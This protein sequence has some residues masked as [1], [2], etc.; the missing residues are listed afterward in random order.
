MPSTKSSS[1]PDK[2][3]AIRFAGPL[4][5]IHEAPAIGNGDLGALVQVFHNE[6]RLHL[7][8]S[9]AWDARAD[10]LAADHVLEQDELIRFERNFGFRWVGD[11][12][13]V[14]KPQWDK[15]PRGRARTSFESPGWRKTHPCPKPLGAIRVLHSGASSTRIDTVLDIAA[16]IVHTRYHLDY[17]EWGEGELEIAAFIHRERNVVYLSVGVLG[18]VGAFQLCIEKT[19][20]RMDPELPAPKAIVIDPSHGLVTQEI[21][22]AFDVDPFA[23]RLAGAFPRDVPGRQIKPLEARSFELLQSCRLDD[24]NA[25]EFAVGVATD[26][27]GEGDSRERALA[28]AGDDPAE[29]YP[30]A[31]KSHRKSWAAFWSAS[32]IALEDLELERS[33]Y[34]NLFA[35][36]CHL[37][38]DAVAPGLCANVPTYDKSAWHGGYTVNMNVQKMFLAALPT[39]HAEW[40]DGYANWLEAMGP[41][42]EYLAKLIFDLEGI[43]SEHMHLPFVPPHR[44]FISNTCGRALGMTGWHGQPLW[45]HWQ[46]RRDKTFLRRRAYP[47]L[48]KA[49]QFY[50]RY[51]DKYLD[52]SG[53]IFPSM[54]LETPGWTRG[55]KHNRNCIVDLI[56]F[57]HAFEW[58]IEASEILGVDVRW[59]ARWRDALAKV[60]AI[61]HKRLLDGGAWLAR[62]KG[63]PEPGKGKHPC[64]SHGQPMWAAW[65]VFPGEM[66][67]GDEEDGLAQIARDILTGMT[68][69]QKH[70][71]FTWIHLWW[72]AIPGLRLGL[73]DAF[74]HAR[75][76]ILGERFPAGHAKTTHWI[77]LQPESWR[78]PEDN[79]LGAVGVTEMLL[80]SQ[81]EVI[82][83][84]PCWPR[85]KWAGFRDFPARGGFLVTAAWR[86]EAGLEAEI[87]SLASGPCR[88]RWTEPDLPTI[89]RDD[90]AVAVRRQQREIAFNAEAGATYQLEWRLEKGRPSKGNG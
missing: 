54:N 13:G 19:P 47:Y 36:A 20:D 81:G 3:H 4:N 74:K 46:Y 57:R 51:L 84:F 49:A 90:Q 79:Y 45:W 11:S 64:K 41:T 50:W 35:L 17:G 31:V 63:E 86:P 43:H 58:A 53:D 87:K 42:F 76:I 61:E 71:D 85:D 89:T 72:C 9:D 12:G 1:Q 18:L 59:R 30:E 15:E 27:D 70:P 29:D 44:S 32:S 68:A 52:K 55:F 16:G 56:M 28:L 33:W 69:K 25:L 83:F 2:T 10:N 23:W 22:G 14:N 48:K 73:P 60:P 88:L 39:N 67:D 8:K 40:V 75:R 82:R 78:A 24:D 77:N 38:P 62:D 65:T 26:R 37:S 5:N 66:V 34:R 7:G 80:Q 21:P 6:F